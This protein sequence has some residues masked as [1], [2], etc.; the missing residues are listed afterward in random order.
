LNIQAN[1]A[2]GRSGTD[3]GS[4]ASWIRAAAARSACMR[5]FV[6]S[7]ARLRSARSRSRRRIR[8]TARFS[9]ICARTRA[10]TIAKSSGFVR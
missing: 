5:W 8:S 1:F 3:I 4:I 10:L 6:A 9:L 2:C 7:S